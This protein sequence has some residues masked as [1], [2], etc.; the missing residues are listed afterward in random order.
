[1][2]SNKMT[3]SQRAKMEH[4]PDFGTVMAQVCMLVNVGRIN[5]TLACEQFAVPFLI[6]SITLQA[7]S[8]SQCDAVYPDMRTALRTYHS[9]PALQRNEGTR[10]HMYDAARMKTVLKGC[11]NKETPPIATLRDLLNRQAAG[12]RPS[13]NPVVALF[14]FASRSTTLSAEHLQQCEFL[15]LFL[16]INVAAS[17]RARVFLWLMFRYLEDSKGPNPFDPPPHDEKPQGKLAPKLRR[18]SKEEF[19]A[20]NV[21]TREEIDFGK[22]MLAYRTEFLNKA[23]TE[24]AQEQISKAQLAGQAQSSSGAGVGSAAGAVE[25]ILTKS[26]KGPRG[27]KKKTAI[28]RALRESEM[29]ASGGS[30]AHDGAS[31]RASS[32]P[33]D[34]PPMHVPGLG[35]K[36]VDAKPL[37]VTPPVIAPH[38]LLLTELERS[39]RENISA[40]SHVSLVNRA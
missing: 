32:V 8:Y 37:P 21:D 40:P 34:G 27:V 38:N 39:A 9:I 14:T 13:T 16:P 28:A 7:P 4:T 5:T 10:Q 19:E 2:N 6:Y 36:Q 25:T 22:K 17:D 11:T 30:Q 18:T 35:L 12:H 1:M 24:F 20:E 26:F 3:G 29:A 23:D 15:D 31:S 33:W